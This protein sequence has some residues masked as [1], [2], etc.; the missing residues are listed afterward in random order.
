MMLVVEKGTIVM[1][2]IDMEKLK[3]NVAKAS[4]K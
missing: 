3:T 4:T 2:L 1:Q